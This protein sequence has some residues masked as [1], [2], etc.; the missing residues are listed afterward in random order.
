METVRECAACRRLCE[1][2]LT[3]IHDST[4]RPTGSVLCLGCL[5]G[6]D[7]PVDYPAEL[8]GEGG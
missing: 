2:P 7:E 4:G 5:P 6:G 1:P 8:G 3:Y